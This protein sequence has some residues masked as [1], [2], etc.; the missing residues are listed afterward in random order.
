[1]NKYSSK[2]DIAW[3]E[4]FEKYDILNN[5]NLNGSFT[6]SADQIREFR[7]P[8]LMAKFDHKINLPKL[9]SKNDL[10]ILPISRGDY[11]I[12]H[13]QAYQ[14]L[15]VLGIQDTTFHKVTLPAHIQSLDVNNISS[16]TIA[17]NCAFAT[18]IISDFLEENLEDKNNLL[19][20]VSGRMG[21]DKFD[22]NIFNSKSN[23]NVPVKVYN[24]QI[25]IDAAFEGI[26]SLALIEAKIDLP[27]NFL[28]RQLYYPFRVWTNRISKPVR[29]IFLVYSNSV[30]SLYEYKFDDLDSYNSLR[31]IKHKNYMIEE[32][33]AINLNDINDSIKNL[34]LKQEPQDIPFPQADKFERLINLCELLF[35]QEL[36]KDD[37]TEKYNFDKRQTDYYT[38]AGIYLGLIKKIKDKKITYQLT[39]KGYK[40]MQLPYKQ[41]QLEWVKCILQYKVFG[42]TFNELQNKGKIPDKETVVKIMKTSHLY[43]IKSNSTYQRRASTITGW[44][45]WIFGLIDC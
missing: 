11:I 27:E 20:T 35:I 4:L 7:E 24:S 25:E 29:P 32:D 10:S 2:N 23:K 37:I 26:E 21:T 1:M 8:R 38:N 40:I 44:L 16:E 18:G 19:P 15:G 13:F 34:T 36:S 3:N 39:G 41:R 12:S 33:V 30:F 9:F 31:L 5:I 22:F 45:N 43:E 42:D 28:I 6:I 14:D 17:V